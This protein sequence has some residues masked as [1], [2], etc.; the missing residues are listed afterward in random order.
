MKHYFYIVTIND[1]GGA[2]SPQDSLHYYL[3]SI[4]NFTGL[5]RN[6]L[7]CLLV[8]PLF[9][10]S[11]TELNHCRDYASCSLCVHGYMPPSK[12]TG[13][14]LRSSFKSPN[15]LSSP[16]FSSPAD[17]SSSTSSHRNTQTTCYKTVT[18]SS[19]A[20]APSLS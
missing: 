19:A 20:Q 1:T 5:S 8:F 18:C 9:W 15:Q 11:F 13:H 14:I 4:P 3:L 6:S 2:C 17:L 12:D 10:L 16:H 7:Q